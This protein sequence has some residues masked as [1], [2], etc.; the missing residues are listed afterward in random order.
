MAEK[1]RKPGTE[2]PAKAAGKPAEKAAET[3]VKKAAGK[4]AEKAAETPAKKPTGKPTGKSV[5]KPT[6]KSADKLT[7]QKDMTSFELSLFFANLELIYRSG[8]TPSDG[9]DILKRGSENP[10]YTEWLDKLYQSS[11]HG[12]ALSE[13]LEKAG[14]VPEYALS[15]LRI[16]EATG[17][18]ED[19]CTGLSDYYKKRDELAQSIRSA[20][21]YPLTMVLMVLVVVIVLLT[22]AVPVFDQVFNQLGL[23]LTG[24][25][26]TLLVIG[27]ALR[28][29]VLVIACVLVAIA[30]ILLILRLTPQGK[31]LFHRLYESA[32]ITGDISFR[33]SLQRFT[34]AMSTMLKSGLDTDAALTLAATLIENKKLEEKVRLVRTNIS[35]G[36]GFKAAIENGDLFPPEAMTLLSMGFRV[37]AEAEVFDH[38]GNS[39]ATSTER[40]VQRTVGAIEPALVGFMC[41]L[42][43]LILISVMLPLLGVLSNI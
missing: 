38:V 21:V 43:G 26:G 22:E 17:K 37:G 11:L 1:S 23:E 30:V 36:M 14:G 41:V 3:P 33:L 10:A 31:Q 18:L 24:F 28:S 19:T 12:F 13:S 8:L 15:M 4:P 16:G 6:G 32:P 5:E 20:L 27:Q 2:T 29:S 9:F 34:Y 40:K 39:I 35:K 25:A 7:K 42:V